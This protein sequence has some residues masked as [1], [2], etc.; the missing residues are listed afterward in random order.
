[1]TIQRHP[2]FAAAAPGRLTHLG[3]EIIS[4]AISLASRRRCARH[5]ARRRLRLGRAATGAVEDG[6]QAAE[7]CGAGTADAL[8]RDTGER[9]CGWPPAPMRSTIQRSPTAINITAT[10]MSSAAMR[11]W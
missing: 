1:M 10:Q 4:Y 7:I 8:G 2:V 5:H 9:A 11:S 3:P 6:R